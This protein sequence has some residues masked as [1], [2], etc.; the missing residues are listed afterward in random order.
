MR[1]NIYDRIKRLIA[2]SIVLVMTLSTTLGYTATTVKAVTGEGTI[3][4]SGGL[5]GSSSIDPFKSGTNG[6]NTI[7][8]SKTAT[9]LD[10]NDKSQVTVSFP[11]GDYKNEYDIVLVVDATESFTVIAEN[12]NTF[13]KNLSDNLAGRTNVKINVGVVSYGT[14]A[15]TDYKPG[16]N[17]NFAWIGFQYCME[18]GGWTSNFI[19]QTALGQVPADYQS[20]IKYLQPLGNGYLASLPASSAESSRDLLPLTQLST[21]PTDPASADNLY[22]SVMKEGSKY[23]TTALLTYAKFTGNSMA[24]T[25][26]YQ[27]NNTIVGS[28]VEAGIKAGRDMLMGSSTKNENKYLV[29][30]T[31]GGSYMWNGQNSDDAKDSV[32]GA[33]VY[34]NNPIL[35][36]VFSNDFNTKNNPEYYKYAG[37]ADF[38]KNS[39]VLTNFDSA[40]SIEQFQAQSTGTINY[41]SFLANAINNSTNGINYKYTSL[42]RGTAHA[43]QIGTEFVSNNEGRM[44]FMGSAYRPEYFNQPGQLGYDVTTDFRSYMGGLSDS[45]YPISNTT[46][47]DDV[48]A[49]FDGIVNRMFYLIESGTFTDVIGSEFDVALAGKTIT[50]QDV[51]IM[52]DGSEVTGTVDSSDANKINFGTPDEKGVYPYV[53]T[54]QAGSNE[55]FV[56]NINVPIDTAKGLKFIYNIKLNRATA[57]SGWHNDVKLN[58][59]AIIEYKDTDGKPGTATFPVPK[60]KYYVPEVQKEEV[61]LSYDANGANNII[62]PNNTVYKKG[63]KVIVQAPKFA[64]DV[65]GFKF[66]GWNTKADGKGKMYKPGD[67]FIINSDTVLYAIYE[68]GTPPTGS[69]YAFLAMLFILP[70]IGLACIYRRN[71]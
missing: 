14:V 24:S 66:I 56:L 35:A 29:V 26:G 10:S 46:Q 25:L 8:G 21:D 53:L 62:V 18:N 61:I 12:V 52:V 11:A 5:N 7:S 60:T 68:Q 45:S 37:F 33:T 59:S 36:H 44:V 28:N 32:Q 43:A 55:K 34:N 6:A 38:L 42:E 51:K 3:T 22:K 47:A 41:N 27:M 2:L 23:V 65:K 58:E 49:A 64:K 31:D 57:P 30:V 9:N 54:Y 63:D 13:L 50:P 67:T 69:D 39:D 1:N 4:Y 17:S 15:Y 40:L 16:S 70:T 19:C 20:M 48:V 71:Y